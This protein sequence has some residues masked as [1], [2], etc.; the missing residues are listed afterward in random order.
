MY[1]PKSQIKSNLYTNGDKYALSTNQKAYTGYYYS[2]SGGTNYT[3]KYPNDGKNIRLIPIISPSSNQQ[4]ND[5]VFSPN[6]IMVQKIPL[7]AYGSEGINYN[8]NVSY[9]NLSP[10][11][12]SNDRSLPIPSQPSPLS[13]DYI[14]GYFIRYFVKKNNESLYFEISPVYYNLLKLEDPTIAFELYSCIEVKWRLRGNKNIVYAV[15][16]SLIKNVE[17]KEIWP[18]FF[19]Y[20][21]Y[22]FSQYNLE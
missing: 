3:G 8:N 11:Q 21:D 15:N 22:N 1:Y 16:K 17:K 5:N 10:K 19:N 14:N 9:S 12:K 18:G 4:E 13:K 2:T 7:E 6:T 20:F